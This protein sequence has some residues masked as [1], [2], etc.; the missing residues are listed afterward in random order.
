M[1]WYHII[2]LF[3]KGIISARFFIFNNDY[4]FSFFF[5]KNTI[6]FLFYRIITI[7]TSFEQGIRDVVG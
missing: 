6:T 4:G 5:V 3:E 1:K 7:S 2:K